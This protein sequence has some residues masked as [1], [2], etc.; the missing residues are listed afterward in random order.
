MMTMPRGH[1]FHCPREPNLYNELARPLKPHHASAATTTASCRGRVDL[2]TRFS[3]GNLS[4]ASSSHSIDSSWDDIAKDLRLFEKHHHG[5]TK[6]NV[7]WISNY[8]T[9]HETK[10]TP[11][12]K[13][14]LLASSILPLAREA[15]KQEGALE[16]FL[17][18][19]ALLVNH[20]EGGKGLHNKVSRIEH[21]SICS[22]GDTSEKD[23][24][25]SEDYCLSSKPYDCLLSLLKDMSLPNDSFPW[26]S[27]L[28]TPSP[29]PSMALSFS[30][31]VIKA[32]HKDDLEALQ[33]LKRQG[34]LESWDS[35]N[36][37]GERLA[38]IACREGAVKILTFLIQDE[39][40]S[41]RVRDTS[42]RTLLHEI[43]WFTHP[44]RF[45][46][47]TMLLAQAPELL[48][49]RDERGWTALD[50]CPPK[51][52]KVWCQYLKRNASFLRV[53]LQLKASTRAGVELQQNQERLSE[54]I[55]NQA[56]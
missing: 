35:C 21:S 26:N 33:K 14:N 17:G 23:K 46:I 24:T 42:G 19:E 4:A 13:L 43:C 45:D 1:F 18:R 37:Y 39:K 50:Y 8:A 47:A 54:L 15:K 34:R 29:S 7:T 32:L 27:Y 40:I 2:P 12:M 51:C 36:S 28:A 25:Q 48:F 11:R 9:N 38:H 49:A 10:E 6:K 44:P 55:R 31:K 22:G 41:I 56:A 52:R 3:G 53:I 5:N 16:V 30:P 20:L